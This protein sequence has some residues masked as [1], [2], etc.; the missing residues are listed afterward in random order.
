MLEQ[1]ELKTAMLSLGRIVQTAEFD[2]PHA[3]QT[4]FTTLVTLWL[5]IMQRLGGGLPMKYLRGQQTSPRRRSLA[6]RHGL[7]RC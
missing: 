4:V 5:M 2:E 3:P 6:A 7:Q 1:D